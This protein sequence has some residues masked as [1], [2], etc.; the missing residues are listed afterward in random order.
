MLLST[1]P[2][3][4]LAE[5]SAVRSACS[6]VGSAGGQLGPSGCLT[7]SPGHFAARSAAGWFKAAADGARP[8]DA[9][10]A[11]RELT[12]GTTEYAA[13]L[14]ESV[15]GAALQALIFVYGAA[16]AV[17]SEEAPALGPEWPSPETLFDLQVR[18]GGGG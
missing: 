13:R 7:G 9:A 1:A 10:A 3:M 4:Q 5:L 8:A 12:L 18:G 11:E 14:A 6:P 2:G 17:S 16:P 15:Y